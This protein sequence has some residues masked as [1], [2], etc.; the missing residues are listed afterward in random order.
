MELE[1]SAL[2]YFPDE[3][4]IP[5]LRVASTGCRGCDLYRLGGPAVFGEGPADAKVVFV[6]EV[7]GDQEDRQGRPF[8]GP[9][10]QLLD[11][12]L[13]ECG[14]RRAEIYLTNVV[15]HF[16]W[17]PD[18]RGGKRRLHERPKAGE[19]R[20]CE[21]WLAAELEL[22]EPQVLVCL[23]STAAH[24]LIGKN[25]QVT[26]M[27]GQWLETNFG[28]KVIA[29]VHPSSILRAPD[30]FTREKEFG[31]F[32]ADLSMVAEAISLLR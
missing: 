27:R 17:T 2:D 6:G 11:N 30:P 15:K 9:A 24:A 26:K 22:I 21:P 12:A 13:E 16:K 14:I 28:A 7:P 23:G 3:I 19:M 25:F 32:V 29:T 20:A 18:P 4:D 5:S 31:N 10:G 8:V 1:R